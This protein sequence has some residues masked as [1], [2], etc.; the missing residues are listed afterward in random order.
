MMR[1]F[2]TQVHDPVIHLEVGD[3]TILVFRGGVQKQYNDLI[4]VVS[5]G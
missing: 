1:I 2:T 5:L 4:L 3:H